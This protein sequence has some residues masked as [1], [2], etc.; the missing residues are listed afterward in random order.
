MIRVTDPNGRIEED[1]IEAGV[2]I[3]IWEGRFDVSRATAELV[4]EGDTMIR[5]GAMRPRR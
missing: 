1:A 3:L 5:S 4:G 2:A